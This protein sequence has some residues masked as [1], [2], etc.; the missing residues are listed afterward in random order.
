MD[1]LVHSSFN[2]VQLNQYYQ[3]KEREMC[4]LPEKYAVKRVVF[5]KLFTAVVDFDYY[6]MQKSW[7]I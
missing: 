2:N 7:H 4:F 5:V 1:S 3:L 6:A